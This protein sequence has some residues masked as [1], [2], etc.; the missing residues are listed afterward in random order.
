[1]FEQCTLLEVGGD[2]LRALV[3]VFVV[4]VAGDGATLI[5]DKAVVVLHQ[6]EFRSAHV[7]DCGSEA[8]AHDVRNHS[9]RLLLE[10]CGR[11]MFLGSEVNANQFEGN[12]LLVQNSRNA[13]SAGRD[14]E[15]V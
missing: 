15:T 8:G 14:G 7:I 10:V 1:M 3:G 9:E 13:T 5:K 11:F 4:D 12:L 2:E 6:S